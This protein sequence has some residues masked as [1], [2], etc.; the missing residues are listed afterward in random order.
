MNEFINI[1]TENQTILQKRWPEL[2]QKL[3]QTTFAP[4]EYIE[5]NDASLIIHGIH[6]SSIYDRR[7]EAEQQTSLIAKDA[8]SVNIYGIGLGD[9]VRVLL[10]RELLT[11]INV[12]LLNLA[13]FKS[14]LSRF[15]C[16]DWMSD[17]RVGLQLPDNNAVINQPFVAVP[18]CL[19][20]AE[21]RF[22]RTRDKVS[23]ELAAPYMQKHMA[24]LHI[25]MRQMIKRNI[26]LIQTDDDVSLLFQ[27][28]QGEMFAVVGAGPSLQE[29][30][31]LLKRTQK[32]LVI[33]AVNTA[34]KPLLENHIVPDYVVMIDS[35]V[36]KMK[37]NFQVDMRL[38]KSSKLV[39]F[40][41]VDHE[42]LT[43]WT[44]KRYVAYGAHALYDE[45]QKTNRH[46]VLFTSGS[47]L[48]TATDLA[49]K[50]GAEKIIFFGAD[51]CFPNNRTHVAG[52]VVAQAL[53]SSVLGPHWV[54]NGYGEKVTTQANYRGFLLDLE[55]YI[56][57]QT[58]IKFYNASKI[59]ALI[60][61]TEFW[62]DHD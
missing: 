29:T 11:T 18:S 46:T 28:H 48:H 60:N 9:V 10:K 5:K 53:N 58:Q 56:Q 39:Y 38:L 42:A 6:L 3:N 4:Y 54:M 35:D 43:L 7:A 50:M 13:C 32:R 45:I 59:G 20:L 23:L 62:V 37:Q 16:S 12:F 27:K 47:V 52:A 33:V 26:D 25:Q 57:Q 22:A 21:S 55:N 1:K 30:F 36:E 15:D 51:F 40:P 17:P 31:S 19:I 8:E 34:L 2:F 44:P 49:V 14:V 24:E 61:G 41:V